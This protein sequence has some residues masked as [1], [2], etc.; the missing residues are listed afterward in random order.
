MAEH[1][2]PFNTQ[3]VILDVPVGRLTYERQK[4]EYDEL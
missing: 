2:P 3:R 4:G 1:L